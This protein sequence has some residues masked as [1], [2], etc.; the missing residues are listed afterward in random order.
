MTASTFPCPNHNLTGLFVFTEPPPSH[1]LIDYHTTPLQPQWWWM[2]TMHTMPTNMMLMDG[3]IQNWGATLSSATWQLDNE[4]LQLFIV[5][6]PWYICIPLPLLSLI[7]NT[8]AMSLLVMWQHV[9]HAPPPIPGA[10]SPAVMWQP[11]DKWQLMLSF[12]IFVH[13]PFLQPGV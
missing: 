3:S 13:F 10:T 9:P 8:G 6:S 2:I 11:N 5:F 1:F 7:R 12:I 4:Q